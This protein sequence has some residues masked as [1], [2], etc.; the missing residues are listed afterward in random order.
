MEFTINSKLCSSSANNRWWYLLGLIFFEQILLIITAGPQ[1]FL[2]LS[3]FIFKIASAL[4][5]V[6]LLFQFQ[7]L[8]A[9]IYWSLI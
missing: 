7:I 8:I 2:D 3:L 9:K 1:L 5:R 6:L 4:L